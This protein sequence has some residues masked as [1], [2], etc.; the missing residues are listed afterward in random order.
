MFKFIK[1]LFA[2]VRKTKRRVPLTDRQKD[3][4]LHNLFIHGE[5]SKDAEYMKTIKDLTGPW[6]RK[7]Q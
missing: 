1:N 2:P 6:G 3:Q 7:Q 4:L 5:K